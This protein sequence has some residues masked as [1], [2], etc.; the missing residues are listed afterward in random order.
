MLVFDLTHDRMARVPLATV[1]NV[2]QAVI[3]QKARYLQAARRIGLTPS[4]YGE[5]ER[6]L[7]RGDAKRTMLPVRLDAMAG[8]HRRGDIYAVRNVRVLPN[9]SAYV[10]SLAD[11]K[12][13]YIPV[14]CGNLSVVRGKPAVRVAQARRAPA[15]GRRRLVRRLVANAP[16]TAPAAAGGG[17][18]PVTAPA[19]V[20]AVPMSPPAPATRGASATGFHV[21]GLG[22]I[23]GALGAVGA[24]WSGGG[25]AASSDACP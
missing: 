9:Q 24:F 14:V 7:S 6:R 5:M 23:A 3:V 16:V 22:W 2:Q 15:P 20:A 18:A 4:E 21:P 1:S 11:G 10:V 13:V 12:R 25:G 19:A 17:V 8:L